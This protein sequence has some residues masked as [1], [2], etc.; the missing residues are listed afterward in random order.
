MGDWFCD[1]RGLLGEKRRDGWE[2]CEFLWT[3]EI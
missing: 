3:V 1:R 2:E